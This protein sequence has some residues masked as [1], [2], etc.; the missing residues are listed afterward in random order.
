MKQFLRVLGISSLVIIVGAVANYLLIPLYVNIGFFK[1]LVLTVPFWDKAII[2]LMFC[3][4]P[5]LFTFFGLFI[6]SATIVSILYIYFEF[7]NI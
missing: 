7:K 1:P 3:Y 6:F 2:S 5:W 4:V